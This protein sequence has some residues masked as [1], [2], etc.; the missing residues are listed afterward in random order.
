MVNWY[1]REFSS[2]EQ[3]VQAV[4]RNLSEEKI[5]N[6]TGKTKDF[7]QRVSV[8]SENSK[9]NLH[10]HDSIKLDLA[11]LRE[12]K[13]HPILNAH[14]LQID[15]FLKDSNKH[16]D[17]KNTIIEMNIRLGQLSEEVKKAIDPSGPSGERID[18]NEKD[19]IYKKL[20]E[21][22]SKISDLK[23]SIGIKK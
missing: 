10:H 7:F 6:A 21:L 5:K 4:V 19:D 18:M 3:A 23:I 15:K 2:L 17:I 11:C 16:V 8:P 13:G 1:E 9:K 12:G 20:L 22:E 14:Q